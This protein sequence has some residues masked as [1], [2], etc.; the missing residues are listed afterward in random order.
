EPGEVENAL[1]QLEGIQDAVVVATN[2]H[3]IQSL[4][5]YIVSHTVVDLFE[6]KQNLKKFL[7]SYMIPS[8]IMQLEQIPVTSSGKVDKHRLPS[9]NVRA[10][11][12]HDTFVAA[13]ND[14]EKELVTIWRDILVSEQIGIHDNFFELGGNSLLIMSMLARI[15]EK[16]P[17]IVKV[18]DIF[19]NPT[20]AQLATFIDVSRQAA[21]RCAQVP[22]PD[23]YLLG[24][25]N[26]EFVFHFQDNSDLFHVLKEMQSENETAL[27]S[28][29]LFLYTYSVIEATGQQELS[30]CYGANNTFSSFEICNHDDLNVLL[31]NVNSKKQAAPKCTQAKFII[32]YKQNGLFPMF[33]YQ[34]TGNKGYK[35]YC[36]FSFSFT[37]NEEAVYFEA[38][39][40]NRTLN[41][42]YIQ[43]LF[44]RWIQIVQHVS[45]KE[46]DDNK[47]R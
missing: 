47:V 43:S 11:V 3:E 42:D 39:I 28:W 16:Y 17:G 32:D 25:R 36:D 7:P 40:L 31:E 41:S 19:A 34:F 9:P 44:L 37:M 23:S 30:V 29:L 20:I 15:E 18:G 27:E 1:R 38:K 13:Q 4:C 46:K 45:L 14:R 33:L 22:F 35:E 2:H 5:G 12:E 10:L 21:L 24:S 6:I 26:K 8:F